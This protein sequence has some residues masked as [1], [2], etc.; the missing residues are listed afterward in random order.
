MKKLGSLVILA[1][2]SSLALANEVTE[3]NNLTLA[4]VDTASSPSWALEATRPTS[5]K[6]LNEALEEKTLELTEKINAQLEKS[7]E[8]KLNREIVF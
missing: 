5:E 4:A 2:V 6:R 3:T 7:L 1:L 8:E